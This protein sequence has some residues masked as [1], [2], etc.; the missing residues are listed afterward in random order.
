MSMSPLAYLV[1]FRSYGTWLPGDP[2]GYHVRRSPGLQPRPVLRAWS[3]AALVAPVFV[4]SAQSR[5]V[6]DAAIRDHCDHAGW[7]VR[8]LHV[9]TNHVHLVVS[10]TA[11]PERMMGQLKA[12]ATR[13]LREAALVAPGIRPWAGHGSTRYLWTD[14]AVADACSYVV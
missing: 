4:L 13:R 5:A 8:A 7:S 12:W 11:P 10:G 6:V 14:E 2:R 3:E 1:T 9:R